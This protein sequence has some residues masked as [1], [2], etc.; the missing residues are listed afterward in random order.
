MT[1]NIDTK[2]EID[3]E[4]A[5]GNIQRQI[6]T[7]VAAD[8]A[9]GITLGLSGGVDSAV[10]ATL[11]ARA[12]GPARLSCWYLYDHHSHPRLRRRAHAVA[13]R[14]NVRL[15]CCNITAAM[16]RSGIAEPLVM[17]AFRLFPALSRLLNTSLAARLCRE[18]PFLATL[19]RDPIALGPIRSFLYHHTVA[20]VE[21]AFNAGHVYRRRFLERHAR[22]NNLLL[23]GAANK[24]E[25]MVGWFVKNGIDDMPHS[26]LK[27]LYKTQVIRLAEHLQL[28]EEV[29]RQAPSPDM[30]RGL[31][32]ESALALDYQRLDKILYCLQHGLSDRR[33]IQAGI[34]PAHVDLVRK[35][36]QLSEWKRQPD[37]PAV[38][39]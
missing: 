11:A 38:A 30:L 3:P 37:P 12:V 4:Q 18:L 17:K 21:N 35:M 23:L 26:P 32:D 29:I 8:R 9:D 13:R 19:R 28:P 16:K 20:A 24:S 36:I 31:N 39:V 6:R 1:N 10:L 14:L 2:L 27:H 22:R 34:D 7:L 33:I 25:W 5:A 15:N